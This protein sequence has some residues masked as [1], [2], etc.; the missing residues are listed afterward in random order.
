[1]KVMLC[2]APYAKK[3]I[4]AS[5]I[6]ALSSTVWA[7]TAG[8]KELDTLVV[9][10]GSTEQ[11]VKEAPA[12]ISVITRQDIEK[13]N[14]SDVADAVSKL[15]GVSIVG[16]DPKKKDIT[17]RGL[18]GDYTLLMVDGIR[19]NTRDSMIRYTGGVQANLLP[20]MAAI[21][22][23]E[24]VRGPMS[25]LYGSD[26]M[27]GVI[28]VITRK[29]PEK[30]HGSVSVGSV[31]NQDSN[32][33]N[34]TG[35]EFW[36][37]G[38]IKNDVLGIQFSG[39]YDK[40]GE[41]DVYYNK[42][43][44]N[45][46]AGS[47]N[48]RL[49]TKIS[50]KPAANQTVNLTVT[51]QQL[52]YTQTTGRSISPTATSIDE[53]HNYQQITLDHEGKWYWG[54]SRLALSYEHEKYDY[55]T[56]GTSPYANP[57]INNIVL[58][59]LVTIPLTKNLLKVGTQYRHSEL[60]NI[61]AE[62][63]T[64][65][66]ATNS[67]TSNNIA[68]FAED[69]WFVTD[70]L[71]LTGGTRLEHNDGYG[72]H[73]TPRLYAVYQATDALTIKGGIAKGF[74]TPTLRQGSDRYCQLTKTTLGTGLLCGDPKLKPE[75][76]TTKEIGISYDFG[77]Q[78]T[79]SATVFDTD[80]KNKISNYATGDLSSYGSYYQV[81]YDNIDRAKIRGIELSLNY[82][83]TPNLEWDTNYTY[84]DSQREGGKELTGGGASLDGYAL[85]QTPKNMVKT[86][87]SWQA[88]DQ[89]NTYAGANYY[90]TSEW[91]SSRNNSSYVRKRPGSTTF[92]VGGMY[93]ITKNVNV[94]FDFLN[95]T[96][97]IV[98]VDN[99]PRASL[100]GNWMEDLGRRFAITLNSAF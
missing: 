66:V 78:R 95:I 20:P 60:S 38:P 2:R 10:A 65:V 34:S 92:D 98:P 85:A 76:S 89:L 3:L 25:S 12:S 6:G 55:A 69:D 93:K 28:N 100:Y 50:A 94:K 71:T 35:T 4:I 88:T 14:Y 70:K 74:K 22:R 82:A 91:A 21:E 46:T 17:I 19:Q 43:G 39:N 45:G 36:F 97:K 57:D 26:A 15:E 67:I 49:S 80:F 96:N 90:G 56:N 52:E 81:V 44:D 30:W 27:G 33:G 68:L 8:N 9:T 62:T 87:V 18:P 16:N 41:D 63:A 75:E 31:I 77:E 29:V 73:W 59:G 47:K 1:M 61:K 48:Q 23:I 37:G 53:K 54:T 42:S 51:A 5:V 58:D 40:R 79:F 24:V 32:H 86:K 72:N 7:D 64:N 13:N 99:S 11:T 84:T 83:I